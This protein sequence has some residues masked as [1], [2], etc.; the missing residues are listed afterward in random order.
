MARKYLWTLALFVFGVATGILGV[1]FIGAGGAP[2]PPDREGPRPM[3]MPG[4]GMRQMPM[5]GP[6]PA[7]ITVSGG[8]VYVL[9]G[10]TVF[11]LDASDLKIVSQRIIG[12]PGPGPMQPMGPPPR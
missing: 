3:P 9:L 8:F 10:N 7:G 1:T 6:P 2:M 5:G 4:P 12:E 11:K